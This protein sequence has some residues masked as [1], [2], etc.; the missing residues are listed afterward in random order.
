M[1]W[2]KQSRDQA[3][4]SMD[5]AEEE[6]VAESPVDVAGTLVL[7]QLCQIGRPLQSLRL[8]A[9][10]RAQQKQT[11]DGGR[12]DAA[13]KSVEFFCQINARPLSHDNGKG[14]EW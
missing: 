12:F 3:S 11:T 7:E 5:I 13:V 10:A 14:T 1:V 2:Q 6:D 8:Q 9:A 4:F